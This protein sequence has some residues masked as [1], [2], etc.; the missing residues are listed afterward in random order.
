L[1]SL[2]LGKRKPKKETNENELTLSMINQEQHELDKERQTTYRAD[3]ES[4]F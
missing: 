4:R 2:N 3:L 1:N